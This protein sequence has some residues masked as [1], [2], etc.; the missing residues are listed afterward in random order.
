MD[1]QSAVVAHYDALIDHGDDPVRDP[2]ILRAY[3]NR[4]D[5]AA[6]IEALRLDEAKSVLE[7]GMGTGRLAVQTAPYCRRLVGVD[8]SPKAVA[9]ARENLRG[10]DHVELHC[11]DFL[12]LSFEEDFDVIYSSLTFMHIE[13]KRA[14]VQKI[15]GLLKPGGR[16][17]ISLDKSRERVIDAGFSR[18]EVWPDS[19]EE[20]GMYFRQAGLAVRAVETEAAI[21]IIADKK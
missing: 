14:A 13:R 3:M 6:F 10:F 7:I 15:A 18:I 12:G 4:W 19:P 5:G 8:L 11:A 20:I 2:E 21:L 1:N 17:V 16:A 9:R